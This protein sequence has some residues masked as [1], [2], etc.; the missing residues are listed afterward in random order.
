MVVYN[1]AMEIVQT[2]DE[3]MV[4][5]DEKPAKVTDYK[6]T[7]PND[8]IKISKPELV[9]TLDQNYTQ[10]SF[11]ITSGQILS[12]IATLRRQKLAFPNVEHGV[13]EVNDGINFY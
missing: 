11:R 5:I 12:D 6:L 9:F 13:V 1:T 2:T 8:F 7:F 10:T 3:F 4:G